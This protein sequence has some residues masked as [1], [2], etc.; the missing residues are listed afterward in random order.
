MNTQ[1]RINFPRRSNQSGSSLLEIP[2]SIWLTIVVLFMPM[3]AL[4][5]ITLR[6]TLANIV[7]QEAV[8]AAA[9]ARTFKQA[10]PEGSSAAQIAENLFQEQK[11]TFSGLNIGPLDLDVLSIKVSDGTVS[12]SEEQLLIPADSARFVYQIEGT[13]PCVIDPIFPV[14][15]EI[16]KQIPGLTAPMKIQFSARQMFENTQGLNR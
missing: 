16:F 9:K 2:L 15:A 11:K 14:Q 12:R 10:S 6:C 7:V 1:T 3:L 8:H 5:S 4:A 13:A